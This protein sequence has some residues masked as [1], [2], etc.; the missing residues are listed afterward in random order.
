MTDD[1]REG[2]EPEASPDDAG[3]AAG[4]HLGRDVDQGERAETSRCAFS[5]SHNP[6]YSAKGRADYGW[7]FPDRRSDRDE[8]CRKIGNMIGPITRPCTFAMPAQIDRNRPE[9]VAGE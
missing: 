7:L 5:L 2:F 9:S 4:F 3:D 1:D 8:I 6:G